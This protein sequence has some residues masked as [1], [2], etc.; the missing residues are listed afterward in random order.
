MS[1]LPRSLPRCD[2]VGFRIAGKA[3]ENYRYLRSRGVTVRKRIDMIIGTFCA[4]NAFET[5]H[6]D[7]DFSMMAGHNGL[8]KYAA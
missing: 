5:V 3:A 4:E 8:R 7:R 2:M 6:N 1:G